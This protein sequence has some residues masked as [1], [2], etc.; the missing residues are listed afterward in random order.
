[1][2]DRG[3]GEALPAAPVFMCGRTRQAPEPAEL[4]PEGARRMPVMTKGHWPASGAAASRGRRLGGGATPAT[5]SRRSSNRPGLAQS[6]R[7]R[8][9]CSHEAWSR[10]KK[11][12]EP[13]RQQSSK[14]G[15]PLLLPAPTLAGRPKRRATSAISAVKEMPI[16][17]KQ[18]RVKAPQATRRLNNPRTEAARSSAG[19]VSMPSDVASSMAVSNAATSPHGAS[20]AS[21]TAQS[22]VTVST[23]LC[24][25]SPPRAGPLAPPSQSSWSTKAVLSCTAESPAWRAIDGNSGPSSRDWRRAAA[26]ARKAPRRNRSS[27]PSDS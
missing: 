13:S 20:E 5:A 7:R 18:N 21:G 23:A 11:T 24:T 16:G 2:D 19:P 9:H 26:S 27:Q 1:M 6:P 10:R 22:V 8:R 12:S 3:V 17:S 25:A 14:S 4:V 15:V